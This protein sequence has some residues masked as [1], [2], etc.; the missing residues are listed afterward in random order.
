MTTMSKETLI[1]DDGMKA[2]MM[3]RAKESHPERY[4]EWSE[5]ESKLEA[6][7][8]RAIAA[9]KAEGEEEFEI[10]VKRLKTGETATRIT[11]PETEYDYTYSISD[12]MCRIQSP[13]WWAA[14]NK[15]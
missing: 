4:K 7:L 11:T 12:A 6:F 15:E 2:A 14:L 1:T 5:D 8:E 3:E 10:T 13:E 9:D